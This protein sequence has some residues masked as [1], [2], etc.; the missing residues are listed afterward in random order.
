MD[1]IIEE[2]FNETKLTLTDS[3]CKALCNEMS[4]KIINE[5]TNRI[6]DEVFSQLIEQENRIKE[7]L[8][9]LLRPEV[10][11][12]IKAGW[13][14]NK[15]ITREITSPGA[16]SKQKKEVPVISVEERLRE[17]QSPENIINNIYNTKK[18]KFD[19]RKIYYSFKHGTTK[20]LTKAV[21]PLYRMIFN[22]YGRDWSM[23]FS[24]DKPIK[25]DDP[26]FSAF[27]GNEITITSLTGAP[28]Y[29]EVGTIIDNT[30]KFIDGAISN[31]FINDIVDEKVKDLDVQD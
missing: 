27:C 2:C 30:S 5:V 4:N 22:K 10:E 17:L 7:F 6:K 15:A 1:Q 21:T 28:D 19:T 23:L 20:A 29:I 3:L 13:E 8:P 12:L 16:T 18:N 24:T 26:V 31:V 11:N 9:I 14:G 25:I